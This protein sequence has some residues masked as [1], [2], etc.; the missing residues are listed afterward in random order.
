[1]TEQIAGAP[2]R[3]LETLRARLSAAVPLNLEALSVAAGIR[4]AFACALP[5]L[6]A[7]LLGMRV[8]S[9]IAIVAFWGCLVDQGGAWRT[10]FAA[11]AGFTVFAAIGCVLATLIKPHLWLAVPFVLLWSFGGSMVRVYGAA[12]ATAGLLATVAVLV[13]LDVP[14]EG[15]ADAL[16]LG[17]L[18][19]TG[20][21]WAMLLVLVLWRLHPYGPARRAVGDCWHALAGFAAALGRLHRGSPVDAGQW[22]QVA[23]QRRGASRNAIETARQMLVATRRTRAGITGRS[24]QLLALLADADQVFAALLALSE[25]LEVASTTTPNP[26]LERPIRLALG[27]LAGRIDGLAMALAGRPL[28]PPNNL[29]GAIA[30]VRRRVGEVKDGGAVYAHAADLLDRIAQWVKI[31]TENLDG[32]QPRKALTDAIAERASGGGLGTF[33]T[34]LRANLNIGSIA[35]RHALR[36][37]ITAGFAVLVTGLLDLTRGYWVSITAIVVLQPYMAATWRRTLERVAGSVLGGLIAA[38]ISLMIHA[39]LAITAVIFPLSVIAMAL[40]TVN[41]AVFV[42][43]LTPQFVLI[44][45]LFQTGGAADPDLAGLRALNSTLGGLLGLTAGFLLWPSWEAPHLPKRLAEAIRANRDYLLAALAATLGNA[46]AR[47][48]GRD[49]EAARRQAGLASNN[50]E[51]SLQRLMSEPRPQANREAEPGMM[52][53]ACLRR[54]AGVA[55]TLTL[56]QTQRPDETE[57]RM[58]AAT[59]EWAGSALSAIA[60]ALASGRAPPPLPEPPAL[61]PAEDGATDRIAPQIASDRMAGERTTLWPHELARIRR[62]VD[63]IEDAAHRLVG[64]PA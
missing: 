25:L 18:T 41:Y 63:V 56:L 33:L 13:A 38:G 23:R 4:A 37:A 54:V 30:E 9:W 44:A 26:R 11:M 51:A 6:I 64:V 10:R 31:A 36:L 3:R 32:A 53:L 40:R 27:R 39:P 52:I 28:P 60:D 8:L 29:A 55:A 58:I 7:E 62:Q 42:L 45:E 50:A 17:G 19:I 49:P 5:V 20:G 22:S 24:A 48:G 59:G 46:T 16:I 57:A 21:L 12:T 47:A 15:L 35:L 61:T 14:G 34:P 43:C 1:M 2:A